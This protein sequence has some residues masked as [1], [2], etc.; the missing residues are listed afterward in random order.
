VRA[1]IFAAAPSGRAPVHSTIADPMK[2]ILVRH[3][4]SQWQVSRGG[5]L[6]SELS[7]LGVQQSELL[8]SWLAGHHALDASGAL[9]IGRLYASP[10]RRAMQTAELL[11]GALGLTAQVE[12][13]L[14]E[15]PFRVA[16][17]LSPLTDPLDLDS[18]L[19]APSSRYL[20]YAQQARAAFATLVD[21]CRSTDQPVMAV[22]HG[23][24]I[25]TLL[26]ELL[27]TDAGFFTLYNA[28]LSCL[29]WDDDRWRIT[30]LNLWEHLPAELRTH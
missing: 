9:R 30:G 19:A 14:A 2:I 11:A 8:A 3:G 26:G 7:D 13:A 27:R 24:L 22:T 23:G 21:A 16:G 28:C 15:A 20:S 1:D 12:P 25:K 29:S 5:S 6:D 17:E 18:V 4:H 10:L